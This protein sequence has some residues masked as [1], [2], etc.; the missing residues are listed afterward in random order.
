M[1]GATSE[2][3]RSLHEIEA[4]ADVEAYLRVDVDGVLELA[5]PEDP[6]KCAAAD[7]VARAA[8]EALEALLAAA[9]AGQQ[10]G[11]PDLPGAELPDVQK[12]VNGGCRVERQMYPGL[13][14]LVRYVA[15]RVKG[16][17]EAEPHRLI[18]PTDLV[19]F[20][21]LEETEDQRIDI[22][23]ECRPLDS[24]VS[25]LPAESISRL[26]RCVVGASRAGY[27]NLFAI[28]EAKIGTSPSSAAAAHAQLFQYTRMVYETQYDRRF[29]WGVTVCGTGVRVCV[30][31]PNFA[32]AS[33]CI[34]LAT[35]DGRA[36]LV[37]LLVR[38]SFC[39]EHQLGYD[40]S[41]A[42]EPDS[43]CWSIQVP[44][45]GG[46]AAETFYTNEMF[47]IADRLFGRHTRCFYASPTV[48]RPGQLTSACDGAVVIKDMWP[49][50]P[51]DEAADVRDEIKHL[52]TISAE[53]RGVD[54][55]AG[56][57]PTIVAG[58][59]VQLPRHDGDPRHDTTPAVFGA[60]LQRA[61][62]AKGLGD[63][64][65][66]PT[67][68]PRI[69]KRVA[70]TPV[71]RPLREL[72]SPY[73]LVVAVAH[74]M[75]CHSEIVARCGILHRDISPNNIMFVRETDGGI[76][77][78]L[79]DFDHAISLTCAPAEARQDRTG[80]LPFMSIGNLKQSDVERT[81]LDDWESV[82]YILCWFG[83]IGLNSELVSYDEIGKH[84]QL[85]KWVFGAHKEIAAEKRAHLDNGRH[86]AQITDE[87]NEAMDPEVAIDGESQWFLSFV[88]EG[89]R[90][91]LIDNGYPHCQG[92]L[93]PH[94]AKAARRMGG[95]APAPSFLPSKPTVSNAPTGSQDPFACRAQRWREISQDLMNRLERHCRIAQGMLELTAP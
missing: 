61:A 68:P 85:K 21:C 42:Y 33:P 69:H 51:E 71:G 76:R 1:R 50:A 92:A 89:L 46:A 56:M 31:G 84:P 83:V 32:A 12:L 25:H 2:Q 74:A 86:F 73:E 38:W 6:A 29:A 15:R 23:L 90:S 59:R 63:R 8:S 5:A 16:S 30:L 35:E 19:D 4:A 24:D 43:A 13:V 10:Q 94:R 78:L 75:R 57:Y 77:G 14:Y 66:P 55:V 52:T 37:R 34:S 45:L 7:R 27:I 91:A 88:V 22:G 67:I 95:N 28:L 72:A 17:D 49:E 47:A 79:I 44:G 36:A 11:S 48:P 81:A 65:M 70:M 54:A 26:P 41:I 3:I 20:K 82:I 60:V 39:E 80:T 58:G 9:A 53:L 18:L 87:F 62:A 40:P 64:D 93:N